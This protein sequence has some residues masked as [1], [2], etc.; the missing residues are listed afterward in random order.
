MIRPLSSPTKILLTGG[1]AGI[2][3]AMRDRLLDAGHHVIVLART[4]ETMPVAP[5]LH[6]V[7]CDLS[8]PDAVR[9][10]IA[11]IAKAHADIS[12]VINNAAL[13]HDRPLI[14]PGFDSDRMADEVAIN[15]LAPALVVHGLLATMLSHGRPGAIVNVN[16][17]LAFFPK[18]R[19]A[20]YCAT[21]AGLHSFSQSLRYQ[22]EDTKIAIVEA[23]LPLVDTN[24]TRGRGSGKISAAAAADAIIA[25]LAK[26]QPEIWIG[27][28]KLVPMLAR[29]APTLGRRV[30]RGPS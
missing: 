21:K 2:G 3:A 16:S 9:S 20:L 18:A 30:L 27:K 23:F 29:L 26:A 6:P 25:G 7:A 12:V 10:T 22:L 11:A 13:Q 19:T 8:D 5:Q 4:A 15:L 24:M 28:A 14:D 17:G 1:T